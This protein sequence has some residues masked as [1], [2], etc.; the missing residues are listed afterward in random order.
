MLMSFKHNW[1]FCVSNE[2]GKGSLL[3]AIHFAYGLEILLDDRIWCDT[4]GLE[5]A[6]DHGLLYK[7]CHSLHFG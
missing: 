7:I 3:L 4:N 6:K 1:I 5:A 2:E